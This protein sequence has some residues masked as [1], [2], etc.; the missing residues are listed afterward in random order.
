MNRGKEAETKELDMDIVRTRAELEGLREEKKLLMGKE[1]SLCDQ[2]S[3]I[4]KLLQNPPENFDIKAKSKEV[5]KRMEEVR[6]QLSEI[7]N[8]I[9]EKEAKLMKAIEEEVEDIGVNL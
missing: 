6:Q 2:E 3:Q 1:N 7:S 9:K 4:L 5:E 8:Y